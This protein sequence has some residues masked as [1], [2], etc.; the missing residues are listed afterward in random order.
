M[1]PNRRR[2]SA[3]SRLAL[4]LSVASGFVIATGCAAGA[5]GGAL[6]RSAMPQPGSTPE[7]DFP[8]IT[9]RTLSNGLRVS[10]VERP[11]RASVSLRLIADAGAMTDPPG[12]P[13]IA[14]LTA[15]MLTE[16]TTSRSSRDIA[17]EVEFLAATLSS[18]AGLETGAINLSTLAR[19]LEP[20]LG[21]FADVAINP[22]FA[23]PEWNRV[24]ERE[25]VALA[26]T[27]D[28]PAIIATEA[29]GRVLYGDMHPLGRPTRGTPESI[30]ALTTADLRAFHRDRYRPETSHLIVVGDVSTDRLIPMLERA[31]A[32]WTRSAASARVVPPLPAAHGPTRVYLIDQPG[33]AQSEIRVGH[34]GVP[35]NHPDFYP[36]M[37]L[38][39]L[40]GGQF[41][42]RI[43]LNLREEKGYTYGARS[44]FDM[45]SIP[46]PFTAQAGVETSVTRES[47]IEFVREISDIRGARPVTAE[48][49]EFTIASLVRREPITLETNPQI[50]DRVQTLV[51]YGL[52]DDYF[53][54]YTDRIAA[55]RLEDVNRV[56]REYLHPDRSA[57]VV[58][59]DRSVVESGLRQL[60]YPLEIVGPTP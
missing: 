32:G 28:Q 29:F 53:D 3:R 13:G 25:L 4:R 52:P 46:G 19:N 54:H 15:A 30:R 31:F 5:G 7:Y 35:R 27:R 34:V 44:S 9:R 37:V 40:L 59:G 18:G 56:A 23:E 26:Q 60:P 58:V 42:S 10:I 41:T 51:L 17:D 48:E 6:D 22:A 1:T 8:E 24:R 16:G 14:S 49:L 33:A 47:V 36:L 20:A 38:N 55:V 39:T 50:L 57:I 43:N 45:R 21:I 2:A 11:G 12:R